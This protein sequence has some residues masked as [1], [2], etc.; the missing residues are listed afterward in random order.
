MTDHLL[1][2]VEEGVM[3]LT[4]NRPEKRNAL[5]DEMYA[6]LNDALA[7][8]ERDDAVRVILFQSAGDHFTAGNDLASFAQ[9]AETPRRR[10][11]PPPP[12]E[13]FIRGI[14]AAGKPV[15]AAV[16]GQG[17]G[18][19]LTMLLHCD[20][21]YIAEDAKL[22]APFVSLALVP[23]AASSLLL[24]A[25]LGHARAF[26]IFAGGQIVSGRSAVDWGLANQA[27]PAADVDGAARE[28]AKA[29]ARQPREALRITK[30][31]MRDSER[32]AARIDEELGH[33]ATRLTSSEAKE[34]FRAFAERRAPDFAKAEAEIAWDRTG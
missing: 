14:G 30:R 11:D 23:E 17:V 9:Q 2:H 33:F 8:A 7:S 18:I 1:Q 27:L 3:T 31:L 20:L 16:R 21:V 5:T 24:V 13:G 10:N 29:L 28:A 4:F 22:S 25:R 19:G 12:V 26:S 15:V 6:A 34:A 32:I